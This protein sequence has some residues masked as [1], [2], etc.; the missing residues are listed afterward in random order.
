MLEADEGVS[1]N[2]DPVFADSNQNTHRS[3]TGSLT[4]VK[5]ASGQLRYR[6]S[7]T[8]EPRFQHLSGRD[9]DPDGPI[10]PE[11]LTRIFSLNS[12]SSVYCRRVGQGAWHIVTHPHKDPVI[13][14]L[15]EFKSKRFRVPL[16]IPNGDL[17]AVCFQ[18]LIEVPDAP[19]DPTFKIN[20]RLVAKRGQV[21]ESCCLAS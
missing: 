14:A 15:E 10:E 17:K 5:D 8:L 7:P 2:T 20:L 9:L 1:S 18:E 16:R 3:H 4:V 12:P 6:R 19:V 21:R 13:S 11:Y